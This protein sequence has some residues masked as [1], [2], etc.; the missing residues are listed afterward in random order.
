M[1]A[2]GWSEAT[3]KAR[4]GPGRLRRKPLHLIFTAVWRLCLCFRQ[5]TLRYLSRKPAKQRVLTYNDKH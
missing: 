3:T 4:E 5:R 2:S 1:S